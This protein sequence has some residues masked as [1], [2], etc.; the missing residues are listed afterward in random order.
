MQGRILWKFIVSGAM[1]LT[2]AAILLSFSVAR[3]QIA[4]EPEFFMT[5]SASNSYAPGLYPD[6]ILPNQSSQI[7]ASFELIAN[8]K[9]VDVSNQ[10]IYWYLNDNLLGGGLGVQHFTF[11]P[12]DE[13]PATEELKVDLPN[14]PGGILI[15][16]I[17]VPIVQPTAV[18]L[19]PYPGSQ[20]SGNSL[21]LTALPYFFNASSVAPLSFSWTVNGQ[22]VTSAEN[23]TSLQISLPAST[24]A[25]YDVDVTLNVNNTVD[26]MSSNA[27]TNLTYQPQL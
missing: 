13:A 10:V 4:G 12:R 16:Q 27:N 11:T 22:A 8:G 2:M 25:G 7:T 15:H 1:A 23:P 20:F 3:A 24:P 5:W 14:Y 17:A 19:A 21:N 6:K 26:N 18:I 9:T